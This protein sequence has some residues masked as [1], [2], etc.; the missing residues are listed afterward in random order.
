MTGKERAR[1]ALAGDRVDRMPVTALY[2]QLYHL[3]HFA[4]LSG[5]AP[6]EFRRWLHET[7]AEHVA[8]YRAMIEAAPLE[9]LQPQGAPSREEREDA[10]FFEKDGRVFRRS[11]SDGSVTPLPPVVTAGHATDYR[12][13]E[14]QHVFDR[15]DV[16]RR[17]VIQRAEDALAAGHND[18]LDAAVA[19]F[20]DDHFIISGGVAGTIW[21]SAE[22]VGQANSLVMLIEQP[23]LMEHLCRRILERNIETIRR[24]AAA[25]GDAIYLDDATA[26]CDMIS[27]D[28]YERFSLPHLREMVREVHRLG[29][30][31]I[32]I[33]FGGVSDRLEQ[34][35]STGADALLVEASM[36]GYVNDID[37]IAE[38]LGGRMTLFGNMDPYG[39]LERAS[40]EG[41]AAEIARQVAAGRKARGFL[42]SPASPI[43][44]GTPLS[45]VRKY[46]EL[47]RELGTT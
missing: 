19:A 6:W 34:I 33:Y 38:T 24:F 35:A 44:P 17:V 4:E 39:V 32:L 37:A 31:A 43:T 9:T 40:E 10:E 11:R 2:S 8:T 5:R 45:R 22:Y 3:D 42:I 46:L 30:R 36:K 13:N 1:A 47:G 16:D 14:T 41:L 26:T 21:E 29:H 7:P 18:Y 28:H 15:R 25:G 20:G 12:A 23:D 27:V